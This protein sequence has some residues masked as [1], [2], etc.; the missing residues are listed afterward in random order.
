MTMTRITN[1]DTLKIIEICLSWCSFLCGYK[2][3]NTFNDYP[4]SCDLLVKS[5]HICTYTIF[6]LQ[7][8]NITVLY[9]CFI[10]ADK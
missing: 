1:S 9:S 2:C 5:H 7:W 6:I 3:I 8:L 4:A 10:S